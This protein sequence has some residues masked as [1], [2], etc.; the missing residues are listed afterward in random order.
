ST[1]A[2][3]HPL[4]NATVSR[5]AAIE[6]AA[7]GISIH[8]RLDLAEIP[9]LLA[10]ADADSDGDGTTETGEWDA[11][12]QQRT[13]AVRCGIELSAD[14][15]PVALALR[16]FD[17][18]LV[19]GAAG[20]PSLRV[21]LVLHSAEVIDTPRTVDY[22]D[23]RRSD[24]SGWKEVTASAGDGVRIVLSDVPSA[25]PSAGLTDYPAL[26]SGLPEVLTARIELE[27]LPVTGDLSAGPIRAPASSRDAAD[28][29]SGIPPT[30]GPSPTLAFLELGIHHVAVSLDHL[31]FLLGLVAGERRPR[32]LA[33]IVTAFTA[34]HSLSLGLAAAGLVP[35]PGAWIEP[36]IGLTIAYVGV[37]SLLGRLRHG[38]ALAFGFGL[39]HGL[40]LAGAFIDQLNPDQIDPAWLLDLA[41]FNIGVETAQLGFVALIWLF[42]W[43]M[44]RLPV[45]WPRWTG[46]IPG[47]AVSAAG[48]Y[49]TLQRSGALLAALR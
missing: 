28:R 11:L 34:A 15:A 1:M 16:E 23:R 14:G 20:L 21:G 29:S 2:V 35:V 7:R 33:W 27:A 10:A 13:E 42:L 39:V 41:A 44:G 38:A 43:A 3:A 31:V 12:V 18:Q 49:W 25:S 19:A 47:G 24:E 26:N 37:A 8:Y 4:G 9:T 46:W 30:A 17:W 6:V 36:V 40:A 5:A 45:C 48:I 32:Q 22:R